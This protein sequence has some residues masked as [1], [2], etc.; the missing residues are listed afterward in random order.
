MRLDYQI[1]LKSSSL[2]LLAGSA[3]VE[4][5]LI[6]SSFINRPTSISKS[7]T[8]VQCFDGHSISVFRFDLVHLRNC[9]LTHVCFPNI[10]CIYRAKSFS[11]RNLSL[12]TNF[13]KISTVLSN[14]VS[15]VHC[16]SKVLCLF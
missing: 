7:A 13:Q 16:Y 6:L 10:Q 14:T 15:I 4:A 3:P 11:F 2:N 8:I 12:L 9:T 1:F 5:S